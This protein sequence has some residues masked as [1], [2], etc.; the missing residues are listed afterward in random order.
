MDDAGE[1]PGT[2]SSIED[3]R[4]LELV[5]STKCIWTPCCG[6]GDHLVEPCRVCQAAWM[7]AGGTLP[8]QPLDVMIQANKAAITSSWPSTASPARFGLGPQAIG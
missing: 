8:S 7:V 1:V 6:P 2:L 4:T 5:L 3:T